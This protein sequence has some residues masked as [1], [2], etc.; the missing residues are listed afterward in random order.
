MQKVDVAT[1]EDAVGLTFRAPGE[2]AEKA[3][4]TMD[5][6]HLRQWLGIVHAQ[7]RQA[8]WPLEVWPQWM[9]EQAAESTVAAQGTVLH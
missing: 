9:L 3:S 7:W 1:L 5:A 2:G 6:T 4:V 8:G